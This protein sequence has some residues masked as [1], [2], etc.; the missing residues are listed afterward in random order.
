[1]SANLQ[2][3]TP[4][5]QSVLNVALDLTNKKRE[6]RINDI[7]S[8]CKKNMQL[9]EQEILSAIYFLFKEKYIVPGS[10]L[11]RVNLLEN[12]IRKKIYEYINQYPGIHVRALQNQFNLG[13]YAISW[14]LHVLVKFGLLKE[15]TFSNKRVYFVSDFSGDEEKTFVLR[16]DITN[17][18]YQCLLKYGEMRL[19]ELEQALGIKYN[20]IQYHLKRLKDV[21]LIE[22]IDTGG[23]IKIRAKKF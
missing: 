20:V 23:V 1:M 9:E 6:L 19:M 3:L 16:T 7:L 22:R 5:Q 15:R 17:K 2:Q 21:D 11:T 4:L 18:I 13:S 12:P 8:A 10:R 14:H